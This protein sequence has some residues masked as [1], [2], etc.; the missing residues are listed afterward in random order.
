MRLKQFRLRG[1]KG[2]K[3][4][5]GV[6]TVHLDFSQLE[7][8]LIAIVG[9]NGAGKTTLVENLTPWRS[10]FSRNGSLAKQFCLKDSER[11]LII[12]VDGHEYRVHLVIDGIAGKLES[13]LY[14]D[15]VCLNPDGKEKTYN[16][17]V[18]GVFGTEDLFYRSLFSPQNQRS[19]SELVPAER[20]TLLLEMLGEN[21]LEA[22]AKAAGEKAKESQRGSDQLNGR[23]AQ[24]DQLI[25][26]LL[27]VEESIAIGQKLIED[28]ESS[29]GTLSAGIDELKYQIA[30]L[31]EKAKEQ[32]V[33]ESQ[34]AEVEKRIK[35][36]QVA[37]F[38][39]GAEKGKKLESIEAEIIVAQTDI[40]AQ[41]KLLD[42]DKLKIM[43]GLIKRRKEVVA[44]MERHVEAQGAH[45][46]AKTELATAK[47]DARLTIAR[48]DPLVDQAQL[49]V[50]S[51]KQSAKLIQEVP[52]QKLADEEERQRCASCKFLL[53]AVAARDSLPKYESEFAAVRDERSREANL[54]ESRIQAAADSLAESPYDEAQAKGCKAELDVIDKQKPSDYI[55]GAAVAQEKLT[56]LQSKLATATSRQSEII[57]DYAQRIAVVESD[58]E[59]KKTEGESLAAQVDPFLSGAIL[60][61]RSNLSELVK[62]QKADN[63]QLVAARKDVEVLQE[64]LAQRESAQKQAAKII[65]ELGAYQVAQADWLDLQQA[66]G[67]NGGWASMLVES[68]GDELSVFAN[69]LL[70][71]FGKSW[72][73]EI[74]TVKPSADGKTEVEGFYVWINTPDGVRELSELSGGEEVLVD[75]VLYHAFSH[76]MAQRSGVVLQTKILDEADGALDADRA[77][78]YLRAVELAHERS[79][80]WHTLIITHRP[81][82]QQSIAQRLRLVPGKG[83][84]VERD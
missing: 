51:A 67:K 16:E 14:K 42:A 26:D 55:T 59:A 84:V 20:K 56:A 10:L 31:E 28:R 52:C 33:T 45:V 53:G 2:I 15:G 44:E 7:P 69:E 82:L 73:L 3:Y 11:E 18:A 77:V 81:E 19:F 35:E 71:I 60:T 63:D 13:Y 57:A 46:Q 32:A 70:A 25:N 66:L 54:A 27:D 24:I 48:L 68:V 75:S 36:L 74:T 49:M 9:P 41:E 30:T 58:I 47:S 17:A 29:L 37:K 62:T 78:D 72:T 4:G 22:K 38:T 43:Q 34:I 40:A 1:A 23:K 83:V 64:K 21:K 61:K 80:L 65:L 50:E 12:E 79:G 39:L 6:D 5:L 76:Y 8:G